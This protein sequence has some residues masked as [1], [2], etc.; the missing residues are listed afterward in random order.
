MPK[1]DAVQV[2]LIGDAAHSVTPVLGQGC[3]SS[4][5]DCAILAAALERCGGDID[6][7]LTQYNHERHADVLALTKL[8]QLAAFARHMAPVRSATSF[9]QG[10]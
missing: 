1:I 5:E 4:L 7:A 6:T 2:A 3:N 9:W 8:N 10:S